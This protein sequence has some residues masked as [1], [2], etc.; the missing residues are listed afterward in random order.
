[1][2]T[3]LVTI[4]RL[5][6]RSSDTSTLV[7][8]MELPCTLLKAMRNAWIKICIVAVFG[9]VGN[10]QSAQP[11]ARVDL[12]PD[13]MFFSLLFFGTLLSR[14]KLRHSK[15]SNTEVKSVGQTLQQDEL[16]K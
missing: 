10:W 8:H 5:L 6:K 3:S 1:V 12:P 4:V 11:S 13:F 15:P 2:L 14:T 16:V 7:S 9:M